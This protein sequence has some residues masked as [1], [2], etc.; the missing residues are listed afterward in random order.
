MFSCEWDALHFTRTPGSR[1]GHA[2]W[3]GLEDD[4]ITRSLVLVSISGSGLTVLCL[5][6]TFEAILI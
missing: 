2:G 4:N 1:S 5:I 3:N 6:L